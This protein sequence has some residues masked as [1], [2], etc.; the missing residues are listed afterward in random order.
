[1]KSMNSNIV[2]KLKTKLS[3]QP[4][5]ELSSVLLSLRGDLFDTVGAVVGR[6]HPTKSR[7][8]QEELCVC[9]S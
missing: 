9:Y 3:D 2:W 5:A 1:M 4:F 6:S 8:G 7:Q